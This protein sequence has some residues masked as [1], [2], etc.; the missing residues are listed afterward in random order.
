M[1]RLLNNKKKLQRS[2]SYVLALGQE[3][4]EEQTSAKKCLKLF[5]EKQRMELKLDHGESQ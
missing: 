2:S 4:E 1:I 3:W 5:N